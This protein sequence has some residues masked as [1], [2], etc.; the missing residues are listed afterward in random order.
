MGTV[1]YTVVNGQ[2]LAEKRNGVRKFYRS[3]ALGSTV[4]LYNDTQTK[5]DTFTYWPYGELRTRTGS[6]PTK[7]CFI[8]TLGCRTQA[9]KSIYMR[10]RVMRP[11]DGRWL[12]VDTLWPTEEA[13]LYVR[14]A[15]L[16]HND[17]TG[18][19]P[20][21]RMKCLNL[22]PLPNPPITCS[23]EW[24]GYI[25]LYCNCCKFGGSTLPGLTSCWDFC[26]FMASTYY[27]ICGKPKPRTGPG[28]VRFGP[29][30]W[31]GEVAP[32]PIGRRRPPITGPCWSDGGRTDR[33]I[34]D[35]PG[36]RKCVERAA[37]GWPTLPFQTLDCIKCCGEYFRG[38]LLAQCEGTC[39]QFN[40]FNGPGWQWGQIGY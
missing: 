20:P 21:D 5:T 39:K 11:R 19:R 27:R 32:M 29:P 31:G 33:G 23:K 4:A 25:Y 30:L 35:V 12:T 22:P 36:F 40:Q 14:S 37:V 3:D 1:R 15:P 9:D 16:G 7:Y 8:G 34:P 18:L 38:P 17:P 2:I 13:Y 24:N 6:T 28:G 10:A 26:D